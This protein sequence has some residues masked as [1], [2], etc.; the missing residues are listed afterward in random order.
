MERRRRERRRRLL[1][2]WLILLV[3]VAIVAVVIVFAMKGCGDQTGAAEG[4]STGVMVSVTTSEASSTTESVVST[5][6]TSLGTGVSGTAGLA[7][8]PNPVSPDT[9][10]ALAHLGQPGDKR[11]PGSFY[12]PINTEFEGLTMF[13]GNASRTYYGEGPIP[14]SPGI[15]W[16]FGPMSGTSSNLGTTSTW[17]GT[18]W[19]GQPAVFEREG[20]TW[21]VFGAY[22]WK[23]HFLDAETG[24]KL[25][26][27]FKGGDIFKGSPVVDPDGYPLVFMGCRDNKWRVIAIDREE[28]TELFNLN[29]DEL[30][31][32]IWNDDWDSS[33]VIRNDY[34]FVGGENSHF[35]ILKLNRGYDDAGKVTVDPVIVLDHPAWTQSLLDKLGSKDISVENSPCLVGDRVYFSNSGGLLQGLDVSATL[36]ELAPGEEPAKGSEVYPKVFSFWTGDDTDATIVADEQGFIYVC[37]HSDESRGK[38]ERA[39]A[40]GQIMKF[41][42]RKTGDDETPLLWSV[43]VTKLSGGVSGVWA[44]P[45]IYKDMLYVPTHGG[46]LLGIDRETG[47]I[48][49]QKPFSEHAWG[50]PVVVDKTLIIGDTYGTLHAYDVSDTRVDPPVVWELAVPSGSALE[51]TPAVW[52]GAIY[53][54][55]RDGYFYKFGDEPAL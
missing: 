5:T 3:C 13:R 29:A 27:D 19:T 30:P 9:T 24:E 43:D 23:I 28:P 38:S 14:S 10:V 45:A 25:L 18:G 21:V 6:I 41:D 1:L 46:A 44:T 20:K 48:V 49:W 39:A 17:T 2:R 50:S 34:A 55:S 35:Y 11:V 47:E 32:Q 16:K 53:M 31:N 26:P 36:E 12:G 42:P 22:D 52:K 51:S 7:V 54:G 8:D 37:Q 33:V 4:E 40:V 15:V